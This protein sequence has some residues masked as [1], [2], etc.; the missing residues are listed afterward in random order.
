MS[1]EISG[2]G[3]WA[4]KRRGRGR[5]V[6]RGARSGAAAASAP[7]HIGPVS[8]SCNQTQC[9]L[10]GGGRRSEARSRRADIDAPHVTVHAASLFWSRRCTNSGR[11]T[12]AASLNAP[13]RCSLPSSF[14]DTLKYLFASS[15]ARLKKHYT[16]KRLVV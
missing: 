13:G 5:G 1:P 12:A 8:A 16:F 6:R 15:N 14:F 2:S 3:W 11:V 9:K 7:P 4:G 10:T